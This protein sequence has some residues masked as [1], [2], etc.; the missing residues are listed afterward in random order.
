MFLFDSEIVRNLSKY[1]RKKFRMNTLTKFARLR[2]ASI[3]C[4]NVRYN[5]TMPERYHNSFYH[6]NSQLFECVNYYLH[7]AYE[8]VYK[9]LVNDLRKSKSIKDNLATKSIAN[10]IN[11]LENCNYLMDVHIPIKM[12]N[13]TY[14]VCRGFRAHHGLFHLQRPCLGGSYFILLLRVV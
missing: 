6:A 12:N 7:T 1:Y 3:Y 8:V 5:Y 11:C 9:D 2:N 14:N 13:G 10:I 4:K